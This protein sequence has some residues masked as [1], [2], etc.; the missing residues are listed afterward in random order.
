M[1]NQLR[2]RRHKGVAAGLALGLL[3][4]LL[5]PASPPALA[6]V[7]APTENI[8]ITRW[9]RVDRMN[10]RLA[11][12]MNAYYPI[13][14]TW[15]KNTPRMYLS[16]TRDTLV[17]SGSYKQMLVNLQ[18]P[19]DQINNAIDL[20][21]QT[22]YS[23]TPANIPYTTKKSSS[24]GTTDYTMFRLGDGRFISGTR[25]DNSDLVVD[26]RRNGKE[27]YYGHDSKEMWFSSKAGS[28]TFVKNKGKYVFT[29][30]GSDGNERFD[31]PYIGAMAWVG[32]YSSPNITVGNGQVLN[33]AGLTYL[34]KGSVITVK[35]GGVLSVDSYLLN[36]GRI[37][38]EKGGLV[39]VGEGAGILP[40]SLLDESCGAFTSAGSVV[41]RSGSVIWGGG[42]GGLNITGGQV[43]NYGTLMGENFRARKSRVIQ[44][45]GQG[46]L[47][48]GYSV[49]S[50]SDIAT[51]NHLYTILMGYQ[52]DFYTLLGSK[53]DYGVWKSG[54]FVTY[55]FAGHSYAS[56][57]QSFDFSKLKQSHLGHF[58][59]EYT[60]DVAQ[61]AVYTPTGVDPELYVSL[62]GKVAD[63]TVTVDYYTGSRTDTLFSAPL[64]PDQLHHQDRADR[65]GHPR[66]SLLYG[67]RGGGLYRERQGVHPGSY[68]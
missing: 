61:D 49:G 44:N 26:D 32:R 28:G 22:F 38:V 24:S 62:S 16:G 64:V 67:N 31:L 60:V 3:L 41:V 63:P 36:D 68:V 11:Y 12:A 48:A 39:S 55:T 53:S 51:S 34:P 35:N 5:P 30:S 19:Y 9:E 13:L 6:A 14:L 59:K 54:E 37:T 45:I 33:V 21:F 20:G 2:V 43:V 52:N 8:A 56:G 29:N 10:Y 57:P 18:V 25:E 15:T 40:L 27:Y 7:E 66:P 42:T 1:I 23:V 46:R 58:L 50:K 4:A 65:R 17:S 47:L